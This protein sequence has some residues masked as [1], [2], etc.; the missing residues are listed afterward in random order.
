MISKGVYTAT[1]SILNDDYSLNIDETI[2]HAT[3]SINKGL[4]GV[5]F[6][7]LQDKAS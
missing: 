4:H 1:C 7:V 6:L 5:F 2:N 3:N